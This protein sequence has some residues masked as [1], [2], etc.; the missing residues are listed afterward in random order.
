MTN[1]N[2][3]PLQEELTRETKQDI[4]EWIREQ[5]RQP[6]DIHEFIKTQKQVEQKGEPKN[7]SAKIN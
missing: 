4:H 7:E 5:N 1:E 2:K 3:K 6:A